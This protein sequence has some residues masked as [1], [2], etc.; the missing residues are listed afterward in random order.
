LTFAK[1]RK[2]TQVNPSISVYDKPG[3]R[4]DAKLFFKVILQKV[5]TSIKA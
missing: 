3:N 1:N 5:Y 4:Q 2:A